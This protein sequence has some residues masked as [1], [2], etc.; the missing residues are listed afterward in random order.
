M[1]NKFSLKFLKK[2]CQ[3]RQEKEELRRLAASSE[4]TLKKLEEDIKA[5]KSASQ[6]RE[7]FA[8]SADEHIC[9][10]GKR[11]KVMVT[12]QN[13]EGT[14]KSFR[15]F[16]VREDTCFFSIQTLPFYFM[17]MLAYSQ[18]IDMEINMQ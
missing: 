16:K 3:Y 18:F 17:G 7:T 4:A 11:E 10:S 13:K 2:F 15:V 5:Q 1:F 6:L 12:I 9:A 8:D 14:C